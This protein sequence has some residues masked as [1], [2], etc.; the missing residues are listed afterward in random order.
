MELASLLM[1]QMP[2]VDLA[3]LHDDYAA[4]L[5]QV[6]AAK[7]S[8]G[9]PGPVGE[10]LRSN[11]IRLRDLADSHHRTRATLQDDTA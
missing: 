3:A 1:A 4:A 9:L 11:A 2:R 10:R 6:A 5:E 7:E 8:G